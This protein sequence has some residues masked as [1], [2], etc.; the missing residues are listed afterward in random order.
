MAKAGLEPDSNTTRP[1]YLYLTQSDSLPDKAW[2]LLKSF[3]EDGHAVPSA[4]VN[5][6]IE[7]KI[8]RGQFPEAVDFYKELHTICDSGPNTETFN[9]LLQGT[10]RHSTK[11]MGMF[12]ASEMRSLGVRPD[13]LTYDRLILVCLLDNDY[14]DAFRYLEEMKTVGAEKEEDGQVGWWM[15]PGT[16]SMLTQRCAKAGDSRAWGLLDEFDRRNMVDKWRLRKLVEET[17]KRK[18]KEERREPES[19]TIAQWGTM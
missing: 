1:L 2:Q 13:R 9:I 7:A 16:V 4:A 10:T 5:V 11:S 18:G 17:W 3:T 6:V 19:Q 15:R 8:Q 14:E 12:F